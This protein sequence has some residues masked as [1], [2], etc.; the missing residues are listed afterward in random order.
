LSSR[1]TSTKTRIETWFALPGL[2]CSRYLPEPLPPKQGLKLGI[3]PDNLK[4]IKTSRTTS[5]KTRIETGLTNWNGGLVFNL[6]EPLPP[7]QG[8]KQKFNEW[9]KE[10]S[11]SSRTTSTKTRIETMFIWKEKDTCLI[12][13]NHFHQNKD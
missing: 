9:M 6:P 4:R 2:S 7:K 11:V 1:T 12:F 3:E 5:T 10:R 8:L 13:P